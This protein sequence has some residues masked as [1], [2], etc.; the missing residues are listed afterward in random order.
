LTGLAILVLIGVAITTYF[1]I[2]RGWLAV[3]LPRPVSRCCFY[4]MP[5]QLHSRVWTGGHDHSELQTH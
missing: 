2:E 1:I 5:H 4:T 3:G